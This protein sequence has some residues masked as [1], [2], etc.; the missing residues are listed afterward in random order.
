MH[1]AKRQSLLV[2]LTENAIGLTLS[3]LSLS[4]INALGMTFFDAICQIKRR[5][6]SILSAPNYC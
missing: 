5:L 4:Y 1:Y 2:G 6:Y 3:I